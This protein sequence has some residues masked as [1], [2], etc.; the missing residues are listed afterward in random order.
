MPQPPPLVAVSGRTSVSYPAATLC[1]RG[2]PMTVLDIGVALVPGS[3]ATPI[4]IC[5]CCR[6][7]EHAIQSASPACSGTCGAAAQRPKP[8]HQICIFTRHCWPHPCMESLH[9]SCCCA[10]CKTGSTVAPC[11]RCRQA[12]ELAP[13]QS[14][15]PGRW[16]DGRGCCQMR[17]SG[18]RPPLQVPNCKHGAGNAS[19]CSTRC[20]TCCDTR[21][22]TQAVTSC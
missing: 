7:G 4:P 5:I 21:F 2:A 20:S 17:G 16:R 18:C 12:G 9:T 22:C 19:G 3:C 13:L 6:E 15:T 10:C 8:Q 11:L 14:W 1:C